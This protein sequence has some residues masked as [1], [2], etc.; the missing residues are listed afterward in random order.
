LGEVDVGFLYALREVMSSYTFIDQN[1]VLLGVE[2]LALLLAINIAGYRLGVLHARQDGR[3]KRERIVGT[4]TGAMLA[5]F[6]F[7]LAISLTMADGHFETRRKMIIDEANAIGTSRLRAIAIGGAHGTAIEHLLKEYAAVRLSYFEA[8][9]D[10]QQ[11]RDV[12]QK[13]AQLQTAIWEHATAISRAAPN[14]IS[15]IFLDSLNQT[16]DIASTRRW[17]LEFRIP[18]Y[19]INLLII[20]GAL[21]LGLMGYYFGVCG[22]SGPILSAILLVAFSVAILL[23]I[24]L[25]RPRSGFIRAEQSALIWLIEEMK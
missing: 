25:N 18:S 14:P 16:F 22:I 23:V 9:E 20:F 6:G 24:D 21:A 12:E 15:A 3:D 13:T 5:L 2:I 11:L 1:L 10:R 8:G 17:G 4:I 19:M 7:I